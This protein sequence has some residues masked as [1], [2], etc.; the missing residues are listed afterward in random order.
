M[1][2]YLL[3]LLLLIGGGAMAQPDTVKVGTYI[4]S[5]HDINFHEKEY[6][7]RFWLWF[8]YRNPD[9]DFSKQLDI[10]NAKDIDDPEIINDS[11]NGKAWTIMKMK[12]TMKE[13]WNVKDFPFDQQHLR[14]QIE[15]TLFD[16]RT[17]IFDPDLRG[18][19]YD[20]KEAIDGWKITNFKVSAGI[21]DYETGFGDPR[22][23]RSVQNFSTFLIE[24]DIERD[25]W[26]LFMKIFLGMYIAFLISTISF[27]PHPSEMEPRFGLP[28]GGLFAAV[29]NKYIID[30][31][32]P[33]SSEFTLVDTL[34]ALTF[35]A[36]FGT[37]LV[38]ALALRQYDKGKKEM[39]ERTNRRG[40]R[41]IFTSYI[42]ANLIFIGMALV[43]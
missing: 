39:A 12:S 34:H 29:G 42:L 37:L 24:M 40:A 25:A 17:L 41:I 33:E 4:I 10:P 13:S 32:L 5:V 38:S 31:L 15:N 9:F 1:K 21:N 7:A 3:G 22:A 28:V 23:D 6:T 11:L 19:K 35:I 26:G 30:S 20:T 18:S 27:T 2:K 16:N 43:D 8:V 14:V 36:I